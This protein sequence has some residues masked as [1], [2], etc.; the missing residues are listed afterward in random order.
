MH[1]KSLVALSVAFV[2][3]VSSALSQ[4]QAGQ[5][6]IIKIMGV[7]AEE[8]VKIDETY[9]VSNKGMVNLPFLDDGIRA[10]GLQSDELAR[11]IEKAYR[12]AEIYPKPTI[13]VMSNAIEIKPVEQVVHLAGEV[14]APGPKAFMK[15]L[16]VFQ[17]IQA[18]G[19]ANQFGAMNRVILWR[20]GKQQKIDLRTAEGKGVVTVPDDTIEVPEKNIFGK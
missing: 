8:K 7:P 11:V 10:A 17:A 13:S 15:G 9:P 14:R 5:S 18:A 2:C 1:G 4:I 19:G 20:M 6:V 16:T 3:L 12:D